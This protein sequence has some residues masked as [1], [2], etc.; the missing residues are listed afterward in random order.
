MVPAD[1]RDFFIGSLGASASFIGLLFVGL[2][3]VLQKLGNDKLADTDRILAESS[4]L[5]LINIFF[6]SLV[7]ILPNAS[8]GDVSLVMS[9]LG[10]LSCWRLRNYSHIVSIIISAI[11]YVIELIFAIVILK[12]PNQNLNMPLL[13]TVMITLFS[14]SL[15]RAWGLTGI[16][17]EQGKKRD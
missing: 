14:I 13:E 9:I 3:V 11:V 8:I 16:R 15:F 6:V 4:F 2:S 17:G 7:A 10:I 1:L 12:H 5:S